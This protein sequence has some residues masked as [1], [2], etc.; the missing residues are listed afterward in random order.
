MFCA[1][2]SVRPCPSASSS[3]PRE[4]CFTILYS[5]LH[6]YTLLY[7]TILYYRCPRS[8]SPWSRWSGTTLRTSRTPCFC[9]LVDRDPRNSLCCTSEQCFLGGIWEWVVI[10]TCRGLQRVYVLHMQFICVFCKLLTLCIKVCCGGSRLSGRRE[11]RI[12][13]QEPRRRTCKQ[14]GTTNKQLNHTI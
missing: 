13:T 12:P 1:S 10:A 2:R 4:R 3:T 5:T 6:Y 8:R 11:H 14:K 9:F 7:Y